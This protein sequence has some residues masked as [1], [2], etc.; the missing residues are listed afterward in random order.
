M[1]KQLKEDNSLMISVDGLTITNKPRPN[2]KCKCGSKKA[3][4]KCQC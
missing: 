1:I 2:A 4:K 3:Y